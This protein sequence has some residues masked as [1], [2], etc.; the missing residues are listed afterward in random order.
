MWLLEKDMKTREE[1]AEEVVECN[2]ERVCPVLTEEDLEGW[3]LFR[4]PGEG[5]S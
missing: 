1:C 2:C 3:V 4:V 5:E